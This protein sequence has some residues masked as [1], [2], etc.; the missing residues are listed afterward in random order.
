MLFSGKRK[1]GDILRASGR[2]SPRG[3]SAVERRNFRSQIA[4]LQGDAFAGAADAHIERAFLA[5][6]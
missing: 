6:L 1:D 5:S 3:V 4:R 2:D